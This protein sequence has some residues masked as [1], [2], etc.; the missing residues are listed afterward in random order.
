MAQVLLR[1]IPRPAPGLPAGGPRIEE[2]WRE[3]AS[4]FD[5]GGAGVGRLDEKGRF[6]FVSPGFAEIFGWPVEQILG[7]D[8]LSLV[9]PEDRGALLATRRSM[10]LKG[11]AQVALRALRQDGTAFDADL[12]LVR[13]RETEPRFSGHF[14]F[15]REATR[16][17]E[18]TAVRKR[19]ARDRLTNLPDR[20]GFLD[21]VRAELDR[22][23]PFAVLLVNLDRFRTVHL[24]LGHAAGDALLRAVARRLETCGRLGDPLAHLG[25]DEF[26]LLLEGVSSFEP[27]AAFA[28]RIQRELRPPV[29]L[30]GQ[31]I[32]PTAC[33]GIALGPGSA[34]RPDDLL[35]EAASALRRAKALGSGQI[36]RFDEGLRASVAAQARLE[37]DLGKALERHEFRLEYQPVVSLATGAIVGC[38]ALLR[39]SHPER[40]PVSP[41]DFIPIAEE[42]GAIEEIGAWTLREACGQARA[43]ER[44]GL[45]RLS[46]AVNLSPV[47]I[48]RGGLAALVASTLAESGLPA[49]QLRLELTEGAATDD[50]EETVGALRDLERMGV[51]VAIDDFGTGYSSLARL[52]RLPIAGL[53]IDRSFVRG[54]ADDPQDAAIVRAL[55]R[56]ARQLALEVVAEGVETEEQLRFLTARRCDAIQGFLFSPPVAPEAFARLLREGRRLPARP[57]RAR[58]SPAA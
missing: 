25:G 47:Q 17:R 27:A 7:S 43:W 48:R 52:R 40:G 28:E 50:S 21:R 8:W 57:A 9:V 49:D 3:V 33:I 53:K 58:R 44:D 2:E 29:L 36:G 35:R 18:K 54:S 51:A 19:P 6:R 45:P 23:T 38:E 4:A 1:P 24:G 16:R 42:T 39:W 14:L 55:L 46:V 26:A 30:D 41:S 10:I 12:L 11:K 15:L 5:R 56:L 22:E 34:A 20:E 13:A 32:Y 31:R 37:T